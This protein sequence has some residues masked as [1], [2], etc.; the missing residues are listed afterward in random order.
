MNNTERFKHIILQHQPSMQRMAEYL[1]HDETI[2]E[3]AVQDALVDLWKQRDDLLKAN[4][5]EAYCI[6]LV[7]RRCIDILR[8]RHSEQPLDEKS[9]IETEP[10]PDDR[11]ARYQQAMRMVAKMPEM[12]RKV[13]LMK[14]EQAKTTQE[15][16][17]ELGISTTN[18]YTTLSRAIS[19]L[20]KMMSHEE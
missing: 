2:A 20:R 13:I 5:S 12:Q 8:R 6:L 10:P 15:I 16:S 19:N 17:K 4:S 11:E 3:D 1:L 9:L 7:K 18:L 14:Y